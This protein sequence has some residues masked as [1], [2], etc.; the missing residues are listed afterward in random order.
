M[1]RLDRPRE[2]ADERVLGVVRVLV[3]V[4]EYVAEPTLV[5]GSDVGEC[6]EHPYRLR[7]EVVEVE[8]VGA[9]QRLRVLPVDVEEHGVARVAHV[10]LTREAVDV[11]ELVLELRD[12]RLDARDGEPEHV[13]LERLDDAL[14]ERLGVGRVV[15]REAR[16]EAELVGLAA[17]DANA[18]RVEG[19]DPHAI[20]STADDVL[21]AL[22]H[23]GSG[24]IG[25]GDREDLA[26]P[27]L[28]GGD[29]ARD[30]VRQHTRFTRP[31]AGH[32]K[33]GG[34]AVRNGFLLLR[35][36]SVEEVVFRGIEDWWQ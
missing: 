19:R 17:Q 27:G 20:R 12:A 8:G 24:L 23:L 28:A 18:G 33:Q 13:G 10:G 22:A 16:R 5:L 21:D 7:D 14:D 4:D 35:I 15:D 1:L 2:L 6:A 31:S 26:R 25:E 11:G 3:L 32:N 30:A 9:A 29:E 34:A 36:E